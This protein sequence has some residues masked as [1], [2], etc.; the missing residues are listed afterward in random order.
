MRTVEKACNWSLISGCFLLA[1]TWLPPSY[2]VA[3]T[4]TWLLLWTLKKNWHSITFFLLWLCH[5]NARSCLR[6][7]KCST[8][9]SSPNA[10]LQGHQSCTLGFVSPK[11]IVIGSKKYKPGCAVFLPIHL[12]PSPHDTLHELWMRLLVRPV[13]EQEPPFSKATGHKSSFLERLE[14]LVGT[15]PVTSL[16]QTR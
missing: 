15:P 12:I 4:L 2:Q 13:T 16:S 14:K 9:T 10:S 7:C 11:T 8:K 3:L 1:C 5:F 6:A